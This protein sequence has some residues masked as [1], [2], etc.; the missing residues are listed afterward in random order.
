M[1][2]SQFSSNCFAGLG[3]F[4]KMNVMYLR[5]LNDSKVKLKYEI[6]KT[7]LWKK[8]ALS[9]PKKILSDIRAGLTAH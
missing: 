3:L 1:W 8:K 9:N 2:V 5:I 6:H 7:L 4:K